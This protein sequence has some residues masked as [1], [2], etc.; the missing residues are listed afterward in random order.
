MSLSFKPNMEE[1]QTAVQTTRRAAEYVMKKSVPMVCS[2]G[3]T[4]TNS[5]N[6]PSA[7]AKTEVPGLIAVGATGK[8]DRVSSFSTYGAWTSVS[9]PGEQIMTT[10]LGGGYAA[11]DGTSFSTPLTAGVVALMLGHGAP[12]D[13]AAIKAK[14]QE[15]AKDIE[16]PGFDDKA[17]FGRVDAVR[18]VLQ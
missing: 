5:R 4:G 10:K 14:L 8:T 3:N 9:A 7:F 12:H 11:V 2:M 15:T 13:P 6:V 16:A 1:Y 17:G 18:A